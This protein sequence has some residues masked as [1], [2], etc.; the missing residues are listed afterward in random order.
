[1]ILSHEIQNLLEIKTS[2]FYITSLYLGVRETD[3]AKKNIEI[4]YKDLVRE[5][6]LF[7]AKKIQDRHLRAGIEKDFKKIQEYLSHSYDWKGLKGI[8]IFSSVAMN[9]WQVY[10]LPPRVRDIFSVD[11]TPYLS[12]L[13]ALLD[14]YRPFCIVLVDRMRAKI[15]EVYLGQIQNVVELIDE[16]SRRT[17]T[18]GGWKGNEDQKLKRHQEE[19]IHRHFKH[20][21]QSLGAISKQFRPEGLVLGGHRQDLIAFESFL[22]H[23]WREKVVGRV[24]VDLHASHEAILEKGLEIES[25][26]RRAYE[27]KLVGTLE[28]QVADKRA[29]AGVLK[30]L[31]AYRKGQIHRLVVDRALRVTGSRC[32]DCEF[33]GHGEEVCPHCQS[34]LYP[35]SDI[36]DDLVE[37]IVKRGGK[38]E[39][40]SGNGSMSQ[41]GGIGAILRRSA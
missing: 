8:S 24:N 2:D 28:E 29:V 12:P 41:L 19:E 6:E 37:T 22:P 15:F 10:A 21:V 7:L 26:H 36:V 18:G 14:E 11:R 4:R 16:I 13:V 9:L 30:T 33:L 1:M 31:E 38:V 39:Y 32:M 3:K 5:K 20:V 17:K 23:E 40:V 25:S 35:I 34:R 27:E